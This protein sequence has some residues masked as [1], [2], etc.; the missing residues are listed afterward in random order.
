MVESGLGIGVMNEG[1][2]RYWQTNTSILPVDPPS[3]IILGITLPDLENA[4]PAVKE[5]V[6]FA[7]ERLNVKI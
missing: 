5:F 2:T 4:A 1:I 7:A 6:N 3:K